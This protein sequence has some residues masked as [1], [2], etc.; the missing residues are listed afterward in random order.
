VARSAARDLSRHDDRSGLEARRRWAWRTGRAAS[1]T[2]VIDIAPRR[3]L[4]RLGLAELVRCRELLFL[5]V[6]RDLKVRYKQ[7]TFGVAWAVVQPLAL[8]VVFAVFFGLLAHVASD[9]MPYPLFS[10]SGLALWTFVLQGVSSASESLILGSSLVSK[11]YFPR[12]AIPAGSVLSFVPD[13]L[14]SI[15]LVGGM[16]AWYGVAPSWR[17]IALPAVVVFAVVAALGVSLWLSALNV[18]Y[19]DVRYAI[20]FLLQIWLFASPVAYPASLVPAQ[21]RTLYGFNPVVG[22]VEAF[23][24]CMLHGAMPDVASLAVSVAVAIA[25]L[26]GGAAYFQASQRTFA[27]VI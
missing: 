5:L 25:V 12:V 17:L 23:R 9:G 24:W 6:R 11:V 26:V 22:L 1:V 19:R 15:L 13:L 16:M 18:R 7:T 3:R 20:P 21:W 27:D 10:Y 2:T 8:M 14:I 4:P